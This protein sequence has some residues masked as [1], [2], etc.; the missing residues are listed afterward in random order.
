MKLTRK[1]F[2]K[3][4]R[5]VRRRHPSF[6]KV[7]RNGNGIMLSSSYSRMMLHQTCPPDLSAMIPQDKIPSVI[8]VLKQSG[9]IGNR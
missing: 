7:K 6:V 5:Q 1:R 4:I 2:R 3:L 8:D 9:I